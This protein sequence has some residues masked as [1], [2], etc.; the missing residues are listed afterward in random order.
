M[1]WGVCYKPSGDLICSWSSIACKVCQV[2]FGLANLDT[3]KEAKLCNACQGVEVPREK[4]ITVG[5]REPPDT[6][7]GFTVTFYGLKIYWN[8]FSSEYAGRQTKSS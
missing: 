8:W 6:E 3:G 1:G 2:D 5:L 4:Y 7:L